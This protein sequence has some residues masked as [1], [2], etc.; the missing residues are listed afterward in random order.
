VLRRLGRCMGGRCWLLGRSEIGFLFGFFL[1]SF[2]WE[3]IVL[4]ELVFAGAIMN[5]LER[6]SKVFMHLNERIR[7]RRSRSDGI[8]PIRRVD[9]G[10][11]R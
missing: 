3:M 10:D 8:P 5:A 9:P 6:Q 7:Y 11:I 1:D 2:H 4:T